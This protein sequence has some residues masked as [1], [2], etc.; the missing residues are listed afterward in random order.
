LDAH[1]CYIWWF[2]CDIL[3]KWRSN[4]N[5]KHRNNLSTTCF[6]SW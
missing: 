6:L 5:R 1:W 3:C 4:W 2:H